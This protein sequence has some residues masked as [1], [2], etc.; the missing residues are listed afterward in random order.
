M[1]PQVSNLWINC[2][3]DYCTWWFLQMWFAKYRIPEQAGDFER[4][5]GSFSLN[6]VK[7]RSICGPN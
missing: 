2:Y 5:V 3:I 6:G 1:W 4:F 7:A